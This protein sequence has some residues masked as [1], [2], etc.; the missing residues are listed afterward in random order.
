VARGKAFDPGWAAFNIETDGNRFD[1]PVALGATVTGFREP[2]STRVLLH[3]SEST[4]TCRVSIPK[5]RHRRGDSPVARRLEV[6]SPL[7]GHEELDCEAEC[8]KQLSTAP[9]LYR[10]IPFSIIR[11][12]R[13]RVLRSGLWSAESYALTGSE[14]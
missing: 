7:R 12:D 5:T 10:S 13:Q 1:F 2:E 11:W 14:L 4:A 3:E 8:V 9:R 6:L